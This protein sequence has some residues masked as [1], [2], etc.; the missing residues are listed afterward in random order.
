MTGV[1]DLP[2]G[3]AVFLLD[4][5]GVPTRFKITLVVSQYEAFFLKKKRKVRLQKLS[6]EGDEHSPKESQVSKVLNI[7]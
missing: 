2:K 6:Q 3:K 7:L 4:A 1:A 5:A